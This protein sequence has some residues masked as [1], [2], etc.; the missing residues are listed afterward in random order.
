MVVA[1]KMG[2]MAQGPDDPR[3]GLATAR[4]RHE[5]TGCMLEVACH[6]FEP[7]QPLRRKADQTLQNR[8]EHIKEASAMLEAHRTRYNIVV[9]AY[10]K[11]ASIETKSPSERSP[12][13]EYFAK[14]M[15]CNESKYNLLQ[16]RPDAEGTQVVR[17]AVE[18]L[19]R[20]EPAPYAPPESPPTIGTR[21]DPV[22]WL[23]AVERAR[24]EEV[25]R[26]QL[27]DSRL[28]N[29]NDAPVYRS[30]GD[31]APATV[32]APKKRAVLPPDT[33]P[34][35]VKPLAM[36]PTKMGA[37]AIRKQPSPALLRPAMGKSGG[38]QRSNRPK[39]VPRPRA[40][41]ARRTALPSAAAIVRNAGL[42]SVAAR[43]TSMVDELFDTPIA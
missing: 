5:M 35:V 23:A 40:Y 43:P 15:G 26:S 7:V 24:Q 9:D 39:M 10:S 38:Q 29:I 32:V 17:M 41:D 18:R 12:G 14:V 8:R 3:S 22:E 2:D 27:E 34:P 6:P 21:P 16:G 19:A 25:L 31:A 42:S 37:D 1:T 13:E 28:D 33:S 11:W 30:L 20:N 36:R 4:E